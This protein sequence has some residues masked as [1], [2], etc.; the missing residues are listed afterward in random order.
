[1][2]FSDTTDLNGI[3]QGCEFYT[4]LG[5]TII[6][7][8]TN[9]LKHFTRLINNANK[10]IWVEIFKSYGGWQY[11][12]SNQSN[13][14]SASDTLTSGQTSYAL[15]TDALT[16]KGVE[17]KNATGVWTKLTPITLEQIQEISPLGEFQDTSSVPMYY[18]PVG[19]TVKIFPASNWTQAS[20]FKVFFD[21]GSV[22]FSHTDTT[23]VPGFE[24]E[25]HNLLAIGGSLEWMRVKKPTS[26][27]TALLA[28]QW[29][30]GLN[31]VRKF[32]SERYAD[33]GPT[34]ISVRDEVRFAE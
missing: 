5:D 20:S 24:P 1:M 26:P 7:G 17:V 22:N 29:Y 33:F 11:D 3:I 16:I 10:I 14:P 27:A 4:D 31:A 6:S 34:R 8:S 28:T 12:D 19:R 32:Y 9:T 13:L 15:P 30:E 18:Y 23:A 2:Q 25:F 21:R